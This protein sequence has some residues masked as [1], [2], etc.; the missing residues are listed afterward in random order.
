MGKE[1]N[2]RC[3]LTLP[4]NRME[5]KLHFLPEKPTESCKVIVCK[6]LSNG[7]LWKF[8]DADYSTYWG[9]F[10][11]TDEREELPKCIKEINEIITAWAYFDEVKE[12]YK[13]EVLG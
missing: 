1:A 6:T 13:D 12:E 4:S 2:K 8:E 9:L 10:H 3:I 5:I 11:M 7:D